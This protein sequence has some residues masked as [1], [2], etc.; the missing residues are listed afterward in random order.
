MGAGVVGL[1]VAYHLAQLGVEDVTVVDR[2]P[3]PGTG[4]TGRSAGG[5]RVQFS[6]AV[7]IRL[8]AW[9][10][11][12]L[13]RFQALTGVDPG[14]RQDG[15]LIVTTR[16][17]TLA[18]FEANVALQRS[19]GVEV[20]L[21]TPAQ[22]GAMVPQLHTADLVGATFGPQDGYADPHSVVL[23]LAQKA[24][25]LGVR[26]LTRVEVVG[27][28]VRDGAVA[29]ALLRP[30][31]PPGRLPAPSQGASDKPPAER[32]RPAPGDGTHYVQAPVVVNAAGPWAAEVARMAGV[33]LPVEP[34]RRMIFVTEPIRIFS[35]RLPMVIDFDTGFYVRREGDRLLFGMA[36][37][38][39]GPSFRTDVDWAFLPAV[40]ER[41]VHRLPALAE[42]RVARGWAGLY[43]VSPD[44]NGIVGPAPGVR[45]LFLA[46]GFS[47]HGFQQAPAVG[48]VVAEMITGRTPTIDV[49]ELS[50]DRF[51]RG[52]AH[53]ERQVI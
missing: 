44:H 10:I 18:R 7:N 48:R 34:Y 30:A 14:L 42:A 24:H 15:Y 52:Q 22:A 17:D 19:L 36:D 13:Q 37:P 28:D 12:F 51:R 27:L 6:S 9:S 50:P 2:A 20:R 21:L 39:E 45:G 47:G 5:V 3:A 16:P 32:R 29:G 53:L 41:G 4:S 40:L 23:G 31:A 33:D 38:A 46:N 1:S 49:S 26:I 43:E 35:P 11:E 25:Q 8:S